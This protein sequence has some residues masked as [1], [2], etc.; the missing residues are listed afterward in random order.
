MDETSNQM[1][2][3]N[4]KE[5]VDSLRKR[6]LNLRQSALV[7][8]VYIAATM[9][10]G[11]AGFAY[12]GALAAWET[13]DYYREAMSIQLA[14]FNNQMAFDNLANKLQQQSN[15]VPTTDKA[16]PVATT[17]PEIA[18]EVLKKVSSDLANIQKQASQLPA[19]LPESQKD[20]EATNQR[21]LIS[22]ITTRITVSF[23]LVFL[24]QVLVNLYRYN[25][26]LSAFYEARSDALLLAGDLGNATLERIAKL[27][28]PDAL[29]FGKM[30]DPPSKQMLQLLKELGGVSSS[31]RKKKEAA[32]NS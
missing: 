7:S 22:S 15:T 13:V 30:P 29:D 27:L 31:T 25:V 19:S 14:L 12:A 1:I 2:L 3:S 21:L 16:V 26:R 17:S 6:A 28:S 24:V 10:V 20:R 5:V 23:L 18:N 11:F 4:L 32:P 8:L 9:L